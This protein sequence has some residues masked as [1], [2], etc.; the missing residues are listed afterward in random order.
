MATF[1]D[2]LGPDMAVTIITDNYAP[3]S[4]KKQIYSL[5]SEQ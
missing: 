4:K 5:L 3:L 2:H 1:Y